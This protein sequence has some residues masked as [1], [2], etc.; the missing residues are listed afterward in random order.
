MQEEMLLLSTAKAR[1]ENFGHREILKVWPSF[2]PYPLR[3]RN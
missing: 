2:S 1:V 3:A